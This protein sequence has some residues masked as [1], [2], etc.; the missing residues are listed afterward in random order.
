MRPTLALLALGLLAVLVQGGLAH[1][2]PG[3]A[4][5]DLSLLLTLAA[6]LVLGAGSGL[7]VAAGV[8]LGA[9]MVSGTLLGQLACLRVLEV[10]VTRAIAGQLDLRRG[11]PLAVFAFA[12]VFLDGI[13]QAAL[14]WLFLGEFPLR[15]GELLGLG[16]R[17]AVTAPFAPLV[18]AVARRISDRLD[19]SEAR[20]EMRLDTR[21]SVLR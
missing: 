12:L 7:L 4:V 8:G 20:R 15:P 1:L 14:S 21:R 3:R 18:G 19:E 10:V 6:A 9:D 16:V 13:G 5:P 2:V 11:L 17:A